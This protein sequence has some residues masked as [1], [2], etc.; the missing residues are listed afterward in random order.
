MTDGLTDTVAE[1][2]KDIQGHEVTLDYLRRELRIDP[3]SSAFDGIRGVM[4]RLIEKKIVRRVGKKDGVYRVVVQ[5]QPVRVFTPDRKRR[6][7]FD[8]RFPRDF[9]TG[10]EMEFSDAINMREGD[11]ITLGG[12]KSMSKTTICMLFC[13]ENINVRPILMGNEYTVLVDDRFEP[14]PR[15][16]SRLDTLSEHVEW[17]DENGLDKFTLLPVKEDY[18]EHIVRDRIN[19]IDWINL[20]GDKNFDIGKVLEGIKAQLGRGVAIIALQKGEGA[21]NPR[22]GQF[23]R[24]FSDVE[25]LLDPFGRM[26]DVLLTVRGAKEATRPIVGKTY[27]YSIG[28][29]GT[30]ILDF[31]EVKKCPMCNGNGYKQ[32]REC[33]NC[34]GKKYVNQ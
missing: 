16:L 5:V 33:E 12:V 28:H 32:N 9:D 7:L 14:A 27:A 29:S 31:R 19:I 1:F 25:L 15:F 10:M 22:G 2:L 21:L 20:S 30:Q 4:K 13:A 17:V 8:L 3:N 34:C 26:G 11:L 18:A 23:V 6:P 24:D